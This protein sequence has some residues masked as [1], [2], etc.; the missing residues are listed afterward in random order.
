MRGSFVI[1][2]S[3]TPSESF[4]FLIAFTPSATTIFP[5]VIQFPSLFQLKLIPDEQRKVVINL[6]PLSNI[7]QDE[8]LKILTK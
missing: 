6:S 3:F 1:I 2:D 7:Y 5:D 4:G 8:C